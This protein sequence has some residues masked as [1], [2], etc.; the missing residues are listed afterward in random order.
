MTPTPGPLDHF[1]CYNLDIFNPP[2]LSAY[3]TLFPLI[4]RFGVH[5][6]WVKKPERL[7]APT[8]KNGEDPG[9]PSHPVHL[10]SY[11]FHYMQTTFLGAEGLL[12]EDQFG[13]NA[14]NVVKADWLFVPTT[15]QLTPLPPPLA[16]DDPPVDHFI[17]YRIKPYLGGNFPWIPPTPAPAVSVV[18]QFASW[19]VRLRARWFCTPVNK[20]G[21]DPSAPMHPDQLTC[22]QIKMPLQLVNQQ[23]WIANQFGNGHQEVNKR[24]V[25]CVPSHI[26]CRG[27]CEGGTSPGSPCAVDANCPD[28]TCTI[29]PCCCAPIGATQCTNLPGDCPGSFCECP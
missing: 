28:G 12:V 19:N 8:N 5:S 9:A 18:D 6:A 25:L 4:D 15:K 1:S 26:R 24:Q 10:E 20:I 13:I 7:C 27:T 23:V 11:P 3:L 16:P 21:E 14:V 17:C 29:P 22:Y 2:Q